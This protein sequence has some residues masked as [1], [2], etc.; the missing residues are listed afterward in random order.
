MSSKTVAARQTGWIYFDCIVYFGLLDEF[1]T[2]SRC[3]KNMVKI[4]ICQ[5]YPVEADKT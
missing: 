5:P 3:K 1:G 4:L 2:L